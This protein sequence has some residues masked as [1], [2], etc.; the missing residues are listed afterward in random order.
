MAEA[1]GWWT[2]AGEELLAALHR[3]HDGDDPDVVYA[4]LYANSKATRPTPEDHEHAFV[5]AEST[6]VSP[7]SYRACRCGL[8]QVLG[9]R[10]WVDLCRLDVQ[11][12][13]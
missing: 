5:D 7:A 8:V 9:F 2:I 12:G 11:G 6:G 4:E 13:T 1:M 10:G 3:V